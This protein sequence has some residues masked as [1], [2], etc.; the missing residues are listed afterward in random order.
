VESVLEEGSVF[1]F[2]L[3]LETAEVQQTAGA[4]EEETHFEGKRILL[5]ED[6]EINRMILMELLDDT[7]VEIEEATD[8]L[9]AVAMFEKS[10]EDYYDLI[11]MDIQMPNLN[12]Y[13]ATQRLRALPRADAG[14]VPIIAMTANAYKEDIDR[15]TEAGMNGH[16]SKPID[17]NKILEALR[18]WLTV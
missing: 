12:G 16:L 8:G 9:E 18:Y 15:A 13:E 17:L 14:T 3:A 2:V 1:A 4:A 7:G 5:V 6:V 10:E 11:F